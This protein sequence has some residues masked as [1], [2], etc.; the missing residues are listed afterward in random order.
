MNEII[1]SHN[2]HQPHMYSGSVLFHDTFIMYVYEI[3]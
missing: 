1:T 3:L 2:H